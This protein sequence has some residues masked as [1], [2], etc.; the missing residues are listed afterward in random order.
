MTDPVLRCRN[1][2]VVI[3]N[4][5]LVSALDLDI[6]AGEFVCVIGC[7]GAGKTTLMH[8]LAGV[9]EKKLDAIELFGKP[10]NT[11]SRAKIARNVALLMQQHEDA[12]PGT[13]AES[14]L[15]GRHPHLGFL[16]WESTEDL[17]TA[18]DALKSLDLS[19]LAERDISTLSGGERQRVAIATALAQQPA[20]YLLDEP[21]NNL[22]P[23]HQLGVL[24]CFRRLCAKGAT[25]VANLH[26]LNLVSRFADKVILLFGPA[27]G[28]QWLSGS[29]YEC[30]TTDNL[31]RLYQIPIDCVTH[32]NH[33]L[34]VTT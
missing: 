31:T 11:L 29:V 2:D 7:N 30:M 20:L 18:A 10:L 28:G 3:G 16:E 4:L 17:Q 1:L 34:F 26:D 8:T 22:D 32:N 25:T 15:L 24:Q 19:G 33:R 9:R 27:E 14:V 12:F 5:Q 21:L 6:S 13:V 23:H